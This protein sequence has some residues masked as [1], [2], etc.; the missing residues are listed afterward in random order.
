M[1]RSPAAGIGLSSRMSGAREV[2]RG[3]T[4]G[5]LYIEVECVVPIN[6]TRQMKKRCRMLPAMGLGD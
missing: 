1:G 2:A 3:I 6:F 4:Q 5:S